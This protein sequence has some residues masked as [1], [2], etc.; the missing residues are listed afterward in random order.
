MPKR[1]GEKAAA[2]PEDHT[3]PVAAHAG[4]AESTD[5]ARIEDAQPRR[6]DLGPWSAIDVG[7]GVHRQG[8]EDR[9][10]GGE[11]S[12]ERPR[13]E[14]PDLLHINGSQN[15]PPAE[16]VGGEQARKFDEDGD[17]GP[18]VIR[19][20]QVTRRVVMGHD[21]ER[22]RRRVPPT[23]R[24]N[25]RARDMVVDGGT[26]PAP[27]ECPDVLVTGDAVERELVDLGCP[28]ISQECL[29]EEGVGGSHCRGAMETAPRRGQ[30]F[31]N[32]AQAHGV[33]TGPRQ[34]ARDPRRQFGR[35]GDRSA[36]GS[37]SHVGAGV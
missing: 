1:V 21:G 7:D 26:P 20:R 16:G 27:S 23:C 37:L 25:V 11:L 5:D 6:E 31:D 36:T 34:P 24:D 3:R 32:R 4:P 9:T 17:R 12:D 35:G 28:A 10:G 33:G 19:A 14:H 2:A 22:P 29:D 30:A 18:V 15:D 8:P 13:P